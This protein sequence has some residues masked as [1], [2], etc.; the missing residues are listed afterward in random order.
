MEILLIQSIFCTSSFMYKYRK[1]RNNSQIRDAAGAN[2]N[3][4]GV[5]IV[6]PATASTTFTDQNNP[7]LTWTGTVTTAGITINN[8]AGAATGAEKLCRA[9]TGNTTYT[10]YKTT[11]F[12]HI[13]IFNLS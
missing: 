1:C 13:Y 2:W 5:I 10:T 11:G 7:N 9:I 12:R 3:N 6:A 8:I 4:T